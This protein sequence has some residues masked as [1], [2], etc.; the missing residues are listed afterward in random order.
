MVAAGRGG[1][2]GHRSGAGKVDDGRAAPTTAG[3]SGVGGDGRRSRLG[4]RA[5]GSETGGGGVVAAGARRTRRS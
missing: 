1:R 3:S 2:D 5:T 4:R